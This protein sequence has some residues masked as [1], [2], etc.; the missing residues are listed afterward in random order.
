MVR[1][2]NGVCYYPVVDRTTYF[3]GG[4][5]L[6][7]EVPSKSDGASGGYFDTTFQGIDK[8]PIRIGPA[9]GAEIWH[10]FRYRT[11]NMAV[12]TFNGA[13]PNSLVKIIIFGNAP[14][15]TD[16]LGSDIAMA[17]VFGYSAGFNGNRNGLYQSYTR[18]AAGNVSTTERNVGGAIHL[19]TGV[20]CS[21]NGA[22]PYRYPPCVR[23][24]DDQ[25]QE[26][27]RRF[28]LQPVASN[29]S[30]SGK[31]LKRSRTFGRD[32]TGR[33]VYIAGDDYYRIESV[34]DSN[35]VTLNG[36]PADGV[37]KTVF[38]SGYPNSVM[39]EWIDGVLVINAADQPMA[40]DLKDAGW[41]EFRLQPHMTN[42]NPEIAHTPGTVWY[43][44]FIVSTQPIPMSKPAR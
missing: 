18:D 8:P 12:N 23:L 10:Q 21:Y 11:K 36:A 24:V 34:I 6:R 26:I 1:V 2:Q 3:S 30:V 40:W 5:A 33:Y 37:N 20:R 4:G 19:Q 42:K 16:Y 38:I 14:P 9:E 39:Q 27:T 28:K 25:W 29:F 13:F 17:S 44:D 35:S 7:I 15:G 22:G 31:V 32:M 43:D 41:G